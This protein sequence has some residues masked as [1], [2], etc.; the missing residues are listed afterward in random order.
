M[1]EKVFTCH[2]TL[3]NL[4]NNFEISKIEYSTM[5]GVINLKVSKILLMIRKL[6]ILKNI[7]KKVYNQM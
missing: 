7:L 5:L 6:I 2:V 1:K 4:E 3:L